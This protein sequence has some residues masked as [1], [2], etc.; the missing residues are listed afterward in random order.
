MQKLLFIDRDGTL[1]EEPS[2]F[3]VDTLGK[4]RLCRG[5]IPALLALVKSGFKLVMVSN[6]DG[7]GTDSFPQ[8][9]FQNCHDFILDLFS[10]QG[11]CFSEIF[12]CPHKEQDNCSCRKPKTGL[13]DTFLMQNKFDR[14]R[15]WV[16]GDRETDRELA[17]NIGVSFLPISQEQGWQG[18]AETILERTASIKRQ[19]KETSIEVA[20]NLDSE[21]ASRIN[22]PIGFFS[23]MLEQIAKHGGF[24]LQMNAQ[25]DTEV[26]EHHLV[27][28]TAL[29]LG[30]A[31][32]KALGDK[33]GLARYGFTLPMDESLASVTIDLGGRSYCAFEGQFTR[34]F[35]G[36]MATE[37]IPHF[38]NSFASSL[39]ATLHISVK[40]QNHH[41]MIEACFKALGRAL[42]QACARCDS[43]LPSTKGVL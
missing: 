23:H 7:L 27:E 40:G 30:E 29:A 9:S 1:V 21:T 16:I 32:K 6:Q 34:E 12:I 37:M 20:V 22:T 24:S 14:Q 2:D 11:I 13:L 31:L 39:G 15:S 25:G 35:V 43:S 5:V 17:N 3:Q 36:G 19:T 4:I 10:S 41:H 42:R 26:D 28:D 8:T 38:F 33:W 18:I